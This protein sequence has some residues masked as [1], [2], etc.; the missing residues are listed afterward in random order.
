VFLTLQGSQ[1]KIILSGD[2]WLDET[3]Y[4][5]ISRDVVRHVDGKKL[6]GISKNQLCIGVATDKKH[7]LFLFEGYGKPSQKK[8]FETFHN[9]ITPGSTLIHDK[10][11]SHTKLIKQLFLKSTVYVSEELKGLPDNE[12][13][14]EPVNRQHALMKHFLNAHA[15]FL[16]ENLQ[17]YLD[18]FSYVTNPPYDLAEKIESLLNLVFQNPKLLRYRD[19][20]IA[21]SSDSDF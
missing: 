3:Y 12:N 7:T 1:D 21:K 11:K 16:R 5:V 8:T 17:G 4:S 10:E 19:F 15:G 14:L 2:V 9:H 18:L 13:P 6:R 20:Y